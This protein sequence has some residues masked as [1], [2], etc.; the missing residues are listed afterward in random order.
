MARDADF[1]DG[2]PEARAWLGF[3]TRCNPLFLPPDGYNPV[4]DIGLKGLDMARLKCAQ[5]FFLEE[6]VTEDVV[7]SDHRKNGIDGEGA[8]TPGVTAPDMLPAGRTDGDKLG[9]L[10][11]Q[12]ASAKRS[13]RCLEDSLRS[14]EKERDKRRDRAMKV[15]QA[16]AAAEQ[17]R[18]VQKMYRLRGAA[19]FLEEGAE[20]LG[21]EITAVRVRLFAERQ[22]RTSTSTSPRCSNHPLQQCPF[23]AAQ[24]SKPRGLV[25]WTAFSATRR[26]ARKLSLL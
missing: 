5:C 14:L 1:A 9:F 7:K 8:L 20:E 25:S 16:S 21:K 24:T 13:A 17:Q 11:K 15:R 10:N 22:V 18:L 2:I 4:H 6:S 3:S 19:A 23:L 26:V 12:I